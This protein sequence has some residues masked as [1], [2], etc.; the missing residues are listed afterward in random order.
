[1][2]TRFSKYCSTI[3]LFVFF[4]SVQSVWGY[5]SV[6]S[7]GDS[8]SD[9]G[10]IGRYS[11]GPIWVELLS[12]ALGAPLLDLAHGG[13]TTGYDNP[14]AG[15]PITGLLWQ[16]DQLTGGILGDSLVTVW[17]G[18][19]DLLQ[20][21]DPLSGVANIATALDGLYA[22]GA[23]NFLVPNLPNIGNT[24]AFQANP[25]PSVALGAT[26]WSMG[27]NTA[28]DLS[29][30]GFMGSHLD[31]NLFFLDVFSIFESYPVGTSEWLSLFWTDG[32]HPS[33]SGHNLIFEAAMTQLYP[34]PEPVTII[35]FGLGAA[36]LG[37]S[38]RKRFR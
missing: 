36:G 14:A 27:F 38:R 5:S 7:L 29:L 6:I 17:A 21:R 19:N 15:L 3:F 4:L 35:L 22:S 37:L 13:A 34:V 8:L 18:G 30:D 32:F 24:P 26:A 9:N 28:L 12:G 25:N 10:N 2:L 11:D 33:S 16:V 20:G 23:R 1:M 31:A